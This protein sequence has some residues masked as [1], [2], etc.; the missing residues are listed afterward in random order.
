MRDR[1]G[2]MAADDRPHSAR[3]DVS[4][5]RRVRALT[6]FATAG[7]HRAAPLAEQ[8]RRRA[9]SG[10]DV[11]VRRR[12]GAVTRSRGIAL[13]GI[14]WTGDSSAPFDGVVVL[15]E[16]GIVVN[17]APAGSLVLPSD[18]PVLGGG[19]S[20]ITPGIVDAHV[21]LAF[22]GLAGSLAG[23]LVGLR[24][25]GA[26]VGRAHEWRSGHRAVRA[27]LP[28]VAVSGPILTARGGYPS[29]S[30]GRD[31]FSLAVD[32]PA[33]AR[34]A[35][36]QLATEGVDLIKVALEPESGRPVPGP[37]T[38]RAIVDTAHAAGLPVTAHALTVEMVGRA[39]DAGADELAHTPI[40]RLTD[41]LIARI[42]DAG[43]AVVSTLQ[44]FFADGFGRAAAAN[45][46]ALVTAGVELRYGTD[47]GNTGTRPGVD[48]RELD[49]LAEAGLGRLGALRAA[50]L[51][52]GRAAGMRGRSGLI[53]VGAPGH[54]VVLPG[55]PLR[56]PGVWRTPS[57]VVSGGRVERPVLA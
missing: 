55:D 26:P 53:R 6:R 19:E 50:T 28:F 56:E 32:S 37:A 44:T 46:A 5:G 47:L 21:H 35:V 45:A 39:L 42:A 11:V 8:V 31:G 22:G 49:R 23:G 40:E 30:W 18:L 14:V 57:A 38:V 54:L 51:C 4:T 24:D 7:F 1:I 17:C 48:P 13:H 52:S 34:A 36:H 9:G 3:G 33:Q 15:E 16:R 25:L 2:D 12:G 27:H 41:E 43:V 20:W 29:R 10:L